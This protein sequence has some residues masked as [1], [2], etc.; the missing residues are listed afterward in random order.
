MQ[1][2]HVSYTIEFPVLLLIGPS[3]NAS[4]Q[5]LVFTTKVKGIHADFILQPFA[6]QAEIRCEFR[7]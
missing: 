1:W 2:L 5:P 4:T 3:S 6:L 7:S